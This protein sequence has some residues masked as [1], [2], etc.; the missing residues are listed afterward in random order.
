MLGPVCL[1]SKTDWQQVLATAPPP[2]VSTH[3]V[4]GEE[5]YQNWADGCQGGHQQGA[6]GLGLRAWYRLASFLY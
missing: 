6:A 3:K 2:A 5:K 4:E 1:S